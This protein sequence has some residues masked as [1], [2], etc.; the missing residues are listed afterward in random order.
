MAG[1]FGILEGSAEYGRDGKE[2][3]TP[4]VGATGHASCARTQEAGAVR[5]LPMRMIDIR[6]QTVS[7]MRQSLEAPGTDE[8]PGGVWRGQNES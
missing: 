6:N 2:R 8:G 1:T 4:Q 3:Q 7:S 5:D